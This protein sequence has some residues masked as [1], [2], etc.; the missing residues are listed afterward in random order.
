M[1]LYLVRHGEAVPK[2]HDPLRPLSEAGV[3][4]VRRVA[5]FLSAAQAIVVSDV[6]HSTKLRARQT[7]EILSEE[8]ALKAPLTEIEQLEPLA[9][10]AAV[11][12][13]VASA[14]N[15]LML[16]GHLPHLSRLASVLV[17]GDA[18]LEAF[19][20]R[21]GAVLCLKRWGRQGT[22]S[23]NAWQVRWIVSPRLLRS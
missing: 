22:S 3:A 20:F 7:A 23:Q 6:W 18:D 16:V 21:E 1:E 2:E 14:N 17:A 5:R 4:G 12:N 8:V 19:D 15:N 13:K 10:L 11:A 9:D